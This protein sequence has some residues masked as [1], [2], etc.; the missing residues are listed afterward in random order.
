MRQLTIIRA[1]SQAS[2]GVVPSSYLGE[3]AS[4]DQV[5][6]VVNLE[7]LQGELEEP[8]DLHRVAAA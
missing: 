5:V 3:E 4:A 8:R 2:D 7:V 1:D 6:A